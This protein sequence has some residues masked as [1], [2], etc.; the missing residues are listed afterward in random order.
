MNLR[1]RN[2]LFELSMVRTWLILN[3]KG[4]LCNVLKV[5]KVESILKSNIPFRKE[6]G[7]STIRKTSRAIDFSLSRQK[8]GS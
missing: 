4:K 8:V 5:V 2:I 3:S 6:Y 1:T 7:C